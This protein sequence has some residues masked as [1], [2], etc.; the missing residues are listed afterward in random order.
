MRPFRD[1]DTAGCELGDLLVGTGRYPPGTVV[2]GLPR[3]GVPVAAAVAQALGC[4]LDIVVVRKLGTPSNRELAMGAIG[5][6]GGM[7][8]DESLIAALAITRDEVDAI[9]AREAAELERRESLYRG[10][11]APLDV[12]DVDVVIVDDGIAT[13]ST[14]EVA[15]RTVASRDPKSIT[16]ATPVAPRGAM[17]RFAPIADHTVVA[18]EPEP[19]IAVGVWYHDF[20]QTTDDEV[21]R[22][23][24]G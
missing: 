21:R 11:R 20:T 12:T 3:G 6:G 16:V 1:R 10:E 4:S 18:R 9:V 5:S 19:F 13:G 23:L 8:L 17:S 22:I 2:L 7:V 14:M 24:S 15:V